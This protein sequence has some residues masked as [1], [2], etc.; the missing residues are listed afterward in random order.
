MTTV[1]PGQEIVA[2]LSVSGPDVLLGIESVVRDWVPLP[3]ISFHY[4]EVR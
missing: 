4:G 2:D 1:G 3:T